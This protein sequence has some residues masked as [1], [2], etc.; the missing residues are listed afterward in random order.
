MLQAKSFTS[1]GR[2]LLTEIYIPLV[3]EGTDVIR[4]TKAIPLGNNQFQILTTIDY[5]P[6]TET[7]KFLPGSVVLCREEKR[8]IGNILVAYELSD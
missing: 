1:E 2:G 5:D 4:P 6:E 7:W 3:G 8:N